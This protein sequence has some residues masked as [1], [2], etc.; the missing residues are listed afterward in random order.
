MRIGTLACFLW[1]HK[2]IMWRREPW[3]V[4][5]SRGPGYTHILTPLSFCFRCGKPKEEK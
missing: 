2:F 1:G 5:D 4:D 3:H